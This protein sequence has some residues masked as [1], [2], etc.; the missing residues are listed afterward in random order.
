[1]TDPAVAADG[2][3]YERALI[4]KWLNV[5]GTSPVT[6]QRLPMLRDGAAALFPNFKA[7]ELIAERQKFAS[8]N[9]RLSGEL[10]ATRAALAAAQATHLAEQA[11]AQ[12][13]HQAEQAAS[14]AQLRA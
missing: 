13:T 2:H 3:T 12:A 7:I 9:A 4:A 14:R 8:E 1:M 11:A 6:R 10:E 5:H